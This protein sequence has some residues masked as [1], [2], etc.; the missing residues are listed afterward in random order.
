MPLLPY[1]MPLD[2]YAASGAFSLIILLPCRH[3]ADDAMLRC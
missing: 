1:A 2:Y 3:V